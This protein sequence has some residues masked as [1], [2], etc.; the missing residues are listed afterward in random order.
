MFLLEG[1]V[2]SETTGFRFATWKIA[3]MALFQLTQ[4]PNV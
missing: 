2:R 1:K 4:K 3:G